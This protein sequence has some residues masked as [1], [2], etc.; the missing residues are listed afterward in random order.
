[1]DTRLTLSLAVA[2]LHPGDIVSLAESPLAGR[3]PAL[4]CRTTAS[5][6]D[7][8]CRRLLSINV[9]VVSGMKR[10]SKPEALM[11]SY[12]SAKL[13]EINVGTLFSEI[14]ESDL[15]ALIIHFLI[16]GLSRFATLRAAMEELDDVCDW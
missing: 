16:V 5:G 2:A 10:L 1:V 3:G 8:S 9:G 15:E 4:P 7:P 11:T 13:P 12:A 6:Q 14:L